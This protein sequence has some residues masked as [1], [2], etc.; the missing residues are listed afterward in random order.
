MKKIFFALVLS[1]LFVS[2]SFAYDASQ[3]SKNSIKKEYYYDDTL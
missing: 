3:N 2:H 1:F